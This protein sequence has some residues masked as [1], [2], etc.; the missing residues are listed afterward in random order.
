MPIVIRHDPSATAVGRTALGAGRGRARLREQQRQDQLDALAFQQGLQTRQ[1]DL[2]ALGQQQDYALGQG[3]LNLG[4]QELTSRE[5]QAELNRLFED[6]QRD[7][8]YERQL[9][10]QER[11]AEIADDAATRRGKIAQI[12]SHDQFKRQQELQGDEQDFVSEHDRMAAQGPLKAAAERYANQKQAIMR[13]FQAGGITQ[14]QFDMAM[15]KAEEQYNQFQDLYPE[16]RGE[17]PTLEQQFDMETVTKGT[18]TFAPDANGAWKLINDYAPEE[19][20]IAEKAAKETETDFKRFYDQSLRELKA[21]E[22]V[23]VKVAQDVSGNL[24]E[25]EQPIAEDALRERMNFLREREDA[26]QGTGQEE[27]PPEAASGEQEN[28]SAD[29]AVQQSL[30]ALQH[31]VRQRGAYGSLASGGFESIE[32]VADTALSLRTERVVISLAEH[33]EIKALFVNGI[34]E[35]AVEEALFKSQ[36]MLR[37]SYSSGSKNLA[38]IEMEVLGAL[39]NYFNLELSGAGSV[40]TELGV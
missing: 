7:V 4:Q 5:Q 14:D 33:P 2:S 11:E 8:A 22:K 24:D 12:L 34:T 10:M 3:R 37:S 38:V 27:L 28:E 31:E 15:S 36:K 9:E 21:E 6:E 25:I 26:V 19:A 13:D 35:A 16:G 40:P 32:P 23:R 39:W 29:F 30:G 18:A 17:E 1:L 20:R